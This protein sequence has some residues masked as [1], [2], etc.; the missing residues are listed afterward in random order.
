MFNF[1][2]ILR[3]WIIASRPTDEQKEIANYRLSICDDC[4]YN[5]KGE[6]GWCGCPID[7][8]IYSPL[9]GNDAC[10]IQKWER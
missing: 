1:V 5:L 6:C 8:K 2:E 9:E 3:A 7:K 10:P 4:E